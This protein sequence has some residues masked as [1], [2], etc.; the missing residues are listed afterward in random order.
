MDIKVITSIMIDTINKVKDIKN[1][2][3]DITSTEI[4]LITTMKN[5]TT[6]TE[7][8]IINME[9]D[10]IIHSTIKKKEIIKN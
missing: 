8:S 2:G 10:R 6:N 3:E 1:M 5:K 4:D 7:D 9:T